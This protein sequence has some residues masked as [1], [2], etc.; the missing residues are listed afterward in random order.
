[1]QVLPE[2]KSYQEKV[3]MEEY[4][5]KSSK[6]AWMPTLSLNG[7]I[8]T[9]YSSLNKKTDVSYQSLT[10]QI[11]WLQ[12][13]PSEIVVNNIST[14]VYS[15]YANPFSNQIKNNMMGSISLNLSVPIFSRFQN[16]TNVKIQKIRLDNS[17]IN[18]KQENNTLR[19]E[20]ELA[21]NDLTN[22]SA[23]YASA[24]E[25]LAST[26]ASYQNSKSKYEAG[27]INATDL[28]VEKNKMIK[29]ESDLL[30]AKYELIFK[31]KILDYY[32]GNKITL[33]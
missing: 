3:N 7:S 19:K 18:Q 13:N 24:T 9:N 31:S 12:S 30:Q 21:Y 23:R 4:A 8:S 29:A 22:S 10:S 33:N 17:K 28:L 6:N 20:I 14:P 32:K 5:L 2:V 15:S 16:N 26:N 1:L 11:G 25:Q 27:L